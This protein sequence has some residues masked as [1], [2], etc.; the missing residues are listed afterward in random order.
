[1]NRT[2]RVWVGF[3]AV[4]ALLGWICLGMPGTGIGEYALGLPLG[5]VTLVYRPWVLQAL[6]GSGVPGIDEPWVYPIAALLPM[7][8]ALSAGPENYGLSWLLLVT[9]LNAG[10]LALLLGRG[11]SRRR[12]AAAWWWIAFT[13]ALGPIALARID[14]VTVPLA[15]IALLLVA[16]HPRIGGTLLALATWIKVWPAA[17]IGALLLASTRRWT[18]LAA[19]AVTSAI[20]AGIVIGAGG[21]AH[22][23]GFVVEQTGRGLQIEAPVAAPYLWLAVAGVGS[24]AIVYSTDILTFQVA[25]PHTEVVAALMTPLLACAGAAVALLGLRA[26]RSGAPL[27]RLFPPLALAFV[28][29]FQLVNKVGSPQFLTWLV[30][31]IVLG[32]VWRGRGYAVPASIALVLAALTQFVY[33]YL[34]VRL[35]AADPLLVA[36]LTVRNIGYVVLW[37]WAVHAV[38]TASRPRRRALSQRT[39]ASRVTMAPESSTSPRE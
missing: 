14:A 21:G 34:Y 12:R 20:L 17:L 10:A 5:D 35:L 6:G 32:I 13:A 25:G 38:V 30:A 22:L 7:I 16:Q 27:V 9:A 36:V 1:M 15:V 18:V 24:S 28:V 26:V 39:V 31:P 11:T 33:P 3:L 2:M 4:H 37:G 8:A 19:G 23:L 29:T